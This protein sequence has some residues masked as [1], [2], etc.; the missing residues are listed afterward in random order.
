MMGHSQ[1]WFAGLLR[2]VYRPWAHAVCC[3]KQLYERPFGVMPAYRDIL[4]WDVYYCNLGTQQTLF[5]L[6]EF[7]QAYLSIMVAYAYSTSRGGTTF[8]LMM[9]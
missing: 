1:T 8:V 9:A 4:R 3:V 6:F 5:T 2:K 7:V